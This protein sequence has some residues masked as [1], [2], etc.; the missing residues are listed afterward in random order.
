MEKVKIALLKTPVPVFDTNAN[1]LKALGMN[2]GNLVFWESLRRLF[3]PD[4]LPYT[5]KDCLEHYDKAILTDLIWIR[6]NARFDYLEPIIDKHQIPFVPISI[7]VQSSKATPDFQLHES[8]VRLLKKMQ[9]RAVL[10]VR[11][12]IAILFENR[13]DRYQ[14]RYPAE[15]RSETLS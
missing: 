8:L 1:R 11:G 10:G 7:G 6:E 9:E 14:G 2:T 15:N 12:D 5:N 13:L 3:N 4:F